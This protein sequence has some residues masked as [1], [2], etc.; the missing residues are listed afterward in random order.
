MKRNSWYDYLR[1]IPDGDV[2]LEFLRESVSQEDIQESVGQIIQLIE[3]EVCLLNGR[4]DKVYIGGMS[5]GV[6]VA[7]SAFL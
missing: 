4:H 3:E 2:T 5:Q 7:L 6:T 1:K